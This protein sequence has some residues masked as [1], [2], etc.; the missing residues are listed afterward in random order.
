MRLATGERLVGAEVRG[1]VS[2]ELGVLSGERLS[3]GCGLG[4]DGGGAKVGGQHWPK[5]NFVVS[6]ASKNVL[7]DKPSYKRGAQ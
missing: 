6:A 4:V 2:S 1:W 7:T 5:I 3:K